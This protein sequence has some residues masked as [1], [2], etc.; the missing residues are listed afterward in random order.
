MGG[1]TNTVLALLAVV[2]AR[3]IPAQWTAQS[4]GSTAS[5]RGISAV[6]ARVAWASGTRGTVLRTIDG[7]T[8]WQAVNVPGADSLD[9][10]D[11][12]AFDD[13][14]A[15]VLSI[16][17]GRASR[18]YKTED[19]GKRWTLQFTNTDTTAFFDCLAFWDANNGMA[20]SDPVRGRFVVIET[21]D[22]GTRWEQL[23]SASSPVAH[24]GEGA[25]AASGSC[26]VSMAKESAWIATAFGARVLRT[27]DRGRRWN[28]SA[29]PISSGAAAKGVFS[30]AFADAS[31]GVAVGGDYEHPT[32]STRTAA[33]TLD[34][35]ATWL[36]SARQPR[37][38]RSAAAW[39]PGRTAHVV[40]VGTS[41]SDLSTDGGRTW[42]ALDDTNLNAVAFASDG[43]GWA[44]G[45]RGVI[46][47]WSP[48]PPVP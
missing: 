9:F 7:G 44:V 40:A 10:R 12:E 34:G 45:P 2:T 38:F 24:Q 31:R 46:V 22:G 30:L 43:T 18:I 29:T 20:V 21:R 8:S 19:G 25:F 42:S 15:Y 39:V 35:G 32:D 13:R 48:K 11:I 16:G 36:A 1:R 4:S 3:D 41:G 28:E 37:G 14:R 23:D 33:Y 27:T 47:K 5:F 6:S 17:N 26:L